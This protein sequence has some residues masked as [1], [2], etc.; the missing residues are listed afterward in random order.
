MLK[1]N[2]RNNGG[3]TL[4]ELMIVVA[5]V[6][7]LAAIALPSYSQYIARSNRAAAKAVLLQNAQFMERNFTESNDYSKDGS[8]TSIT[9][10]DL[11][12]QSAPSDGTAVYAITVAATATT[13]TLTAT[14]ITGGRMEG[15]DCG[16][17]TLNYLGQKGAAGTTSNSAVNAECW[18]K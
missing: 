9:S 2:S 13:Y 8:G 4:I 14:P 5:V 7:I 15:D 6:G 10:S 18:N 17:F 16:I 1:L 11:P 3:F 12:F